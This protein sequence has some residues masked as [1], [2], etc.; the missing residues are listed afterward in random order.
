MKTRLDCNVLDSSQGPVI[1][2][3][4]IGLGDGEKLEITLRSRSLDQL[5]AQL[6]QARRELD[7]VLYAATEKWRK[8]EEERKHVSQ[9]LSV[10]EI[11]HQIE[12]TGSVQ[13][14]FEMFNELDESVRIEVANYVFTHV[15]MFKGLGPAFAEHYNAST[16]ALE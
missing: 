6:D 7:Q 10:E 14:M 16:H 1:E 15:N 5:R 13:R 2:V 4:V 9:P 11:W 3:K 8:L 12:E